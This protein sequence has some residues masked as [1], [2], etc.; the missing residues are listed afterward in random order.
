MSL[1]FASPLFAQDAD[2]DET[3][4][5]ESTD[6]GKLEITG[7]RIRRLDV[8]G[9]S[10][11]VV[12]TR[13]DI[14][15]KGFS[16]VYE[17]LENLTQ[18]T[19]TLQN[20]QFTN[21]F[22][23]NAQS[24]SLRS[25]GGGR[26]LVLLNGRRVADYPQP[27]N[28]QS[29]FFNF[30]TIPTAA[31][32]R[33]EVLTGS[34]SAV[35]G[36][37]AVAGV[38]NIILRDDVTAPTVTARAGKTV[39]GGGES[40]LLSLVWG[41]QWDR[42]SMTIAAEHQA[43]DP[44]Y[45]KDRSYLDSVEDAPQLA[46]NVPYTRSALI[47]GGYLGTPHGGSYYD[48]GEQT[49]LDMQSEGVPYVYA[50][51]AGRGNY[52]G[53]DDFGD[54]TLQNERDRNSVYLNFKADIGDS[55]SFYADMMYWDSA[56]ALQGFHMW[57]GGD[58]WHPGLTSQ[59]GAT[60]DWVSIQRIFHPNETGNQTS[61]F[62]E[63]ASN[64]SFGFEG[65]FSNFWNW[66]AGVTYST[67][68][69]HERQF[70]FKEEVADVYF[71]GSQQ[72]NICPL[73]GFN[74]TLLQPD[75]ST[76]QFDL[77]ST[78]SP[79][80]IDA[81]G[82]TMKIDSDASVSSAFAQLDGD[83]MEM[84]H[85][86]LQFAA[87][88]EFAT[89]E[90][91]ITPDDRLLDQT[92]AGWWGLSGTGGGGDRDR[93]A[94]GIEFGIPVTQ[95]LRAT[96]AG[97]YDNYSDK[98]RVGG[99][100]TYGIGLEYRPVDSLLLRA[101]FNTSFRAPDMHYLFADESGF[102][103]SARDIYKCRQEAIDTGTTYNELNCD[104]EQYAGIRAGNLDLAEEEGESLTVGF[105]FSPMSNFSVQVDYFELELNGAV[106]DMSGQQLARDEADCQ[107]GVDTN[108]NSVD[109][110]SFLCQD[111]LSRLTREP[112]LLGTGEIQDFDVFYIGAINASYRRQKG[113]DAALMYDI[114]TQDA[115]DF[116]FRI[117]YT[118]VMKDER[119]VYDFDPLEKNYR[120]N[121]QNFNARS[122]VNMTAAWDYKKFNAVLYGHRLGSMPNWQETGRLNVWFKYNASAS[123]RFMDDKLI[124]SVMVNNL[125]DTRPP[126]D[127][128]FTT[129]PFFWRG[130]YDARGREVF[131]QLRYTFE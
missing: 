70:R 42:A 101:S 13:D 67:N 32:E 111:A 7:S 40:Q 106:R 123:Y 112:D 68:D 115:G 51:R 124:A 126:K 16:T 11:I 29:N 94:A 130:Q 21:Q 131:A 100:G 102:F 57:W 129:W 52:C 54:E 119:Q 109:V 83:L 14:E 80:D 31:I 90:Y 65:S 72:V 86:P 88:V 97:R 120:D 91:K 117:D 38:V 24:L 64:A 1:L 114:E 50:N 98:S 82:G 56:A 61:T 103:S 116:G 6:L 96:V 58:V 49:C 55:T 36:S 110:N 63:S 99:A 84:K 108:G 73:L 47:Y 92:G 2:E 30:A 71:A 85:G 105:V 53:R 9:A 89:Q 26:T 27:Y 59:Y 66:E 28:S 76:A 22:T 5:Q 62:D 23:P 44:I 93:S 127:D 48:P 75:Y 118:H 79:S 35:Y 95:S 17:A 77:Y 39:E 3:T 19:G 15:Q 125:L 37:D 20:E 4:A 8:E 34:A 74:C 45:G 78:L 107:L 60:G 43:I 81:V 46:G 12:V 128:G 41:K 10:P 121:L 33:V 69:Y 113:F 87:V 25:L 122:T 104:Y 18:N